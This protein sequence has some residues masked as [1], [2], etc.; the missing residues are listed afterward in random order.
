[1]YSFSRTIPSIAI[2]HSPVRLY[3]PLTVTCSYSLGLVRQSRSCSAVHPDSF[4]FVYSVRPDKALFNQFGQTEM[5]G[6]V[7]LLIV[8]LILS[9]HEK[10]LVL[11][12]EKKLVTDWQ[13]SMLLF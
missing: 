13:C 11:D 9:G 7:Y 1:M 10:P 2:G 3:V 5:T 6:K 12:G 8:I 4:V